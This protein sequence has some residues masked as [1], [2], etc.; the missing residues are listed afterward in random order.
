MG[1]VTESRSLASRQG[2]EDVFSNNLG[3]FRSLNA[4]CKIFCKSLV[5]TK[6]SKKL[7]RITQMDCKSRDES[8][9][10]N[11]DVI[12]YQIATVMLQ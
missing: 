9:E 12:R 5:C 2:S 8:N 4:K 3:L 11:Y 1:K 10:P 6:C 7:N